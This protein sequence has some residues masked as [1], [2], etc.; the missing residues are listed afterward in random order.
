M[1]KC[2]LHAL[3]S[4]GLLLQSYLLQATG[5]TA[6]YSSQYP[7][8]MS[9]PSNDFVNSL[10]W[11]QITA[12][13]WD[14]MG[15]D[16]IASFI[17]QCP[18]DSF[19]VGAQTIYQALDRQFYF[20]CRFLQDPNGNTIQAGASTDVSQWVSLR[21][22]GNFQTYSLYTGYENGFGNPGGSTCTAKQALSGALSLFV[23]QIND[24]PSVDTDTTDRKWQ[25]ICTDMKDPTSGNALSVQSSTCQNYTQPATGNFTFACPTDTVVNKM[26][27]TFDT[28]NTIRIYTFT[29]CKYGT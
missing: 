14:Q 12:D 29:C 9:G 15:R 6:A 1:R 22:A 2:C 28:A 3:L 19:L 11:S 24:A 4:I 17:F 23:D 8:Y 16:A 7:G 18:G 5:Y 25:Y 27:S 21:N 10:S 20:I 13:S 26:S